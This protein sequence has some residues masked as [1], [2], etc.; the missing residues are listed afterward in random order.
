MRSNVV[1]PIVAVLALIALTVTLVLVLGGDTKDQAGPSLGDASNTQVE[2]QA[3]PTGD[4]KPLD[5][6]ASETSIENDAVDSAASTANEAP[7]TTEADATKTDLESI[8]GSALSSDESQFDERALPALLKE[9]GADEG[10]FTSASLTVTGTVKDKIGRPISGAQVS[11]QNNGFFGGRPRSGVNEIDVLSERISNMSGELIRRGAATNSD[12]AKEMVVA[13]GSATTLEDGSY[14]LVVSLKH[15]KDNAAPAIRI[16]AR[17]GGFLDAT[18][19]PVKLEGGAKS[20][21]N[22][23]MQRACAVFGFVYEEGTN[24]PYA[25]VEVTATKQHESTDG[26]GRR[27]RSIS[28][29]SG[30]LNGM[31]GMNRATTGEDGN[32]RIEGLTAGKWEIEARW[33]NRVQE[34]SF[35]ASIVM[36][37]TN[38]G[39]AQPEPVV[40][41]RKMVSLTDGRDEGPIELRLPKAAL[42]TFRLSPVSPS[43]VKVKLIEKTSDDPRS[44]LGNIVVMDGFGGGYSTINQ[45]ADGSY[46]VEGIKPT[47]HKIEIAVDGY[48][49]LEKTFDVVEGRTTDLG[50]LVL[51]AGATLRGALQDGN[52][53]PIPDQRVYLREHRAQSGSF[54]VYGQSERGGRSARTDKS[55]QFSF[56][57]LAPGK[58]TVSFSGGDYIAVSTSVEVAESG[59]DPLPITLVA[60]TGGTVKGVLRGPA[61]KKDDSAEEIAPGMRFS[62]SGIRRVALMTSEEYNSGSDNWS[63]AGIS[64]DQM[65]LYQAKHST[66]SIG[67]DGAYEVKGLPT[68]EYV[69][70]AQWGDKIHKV[71]R[72]MVTA[73]TTTTLDVTVPE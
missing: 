65:K 37:E 19:D 55:G 56:P 18:S 36:V 49:R 63:G 22:L 58:F 67:A 1:G 72:V 32:F 9:L 34:G 60:L 46:S 41:S 10:D 27:I 48:Q 52:G 24:L 69:L 35:M 2:K 7:A 12:L 44:Q 20:D 70:L 64:P 25:G 5:Q 42:L 26:E 45:Q 30:G 54:V 14:T 6:P 39:E 61:E 31:R 53:S 51:E 43:T 73:G 13:S 8:D 15:H 50:L 28:L 17:A 62:R 23:T 47:H 29:I 71:E 40:S 11:A 68:G 4:L 57:G 38:E 33:K 3:R 21:I 16:K 59:A 66:M